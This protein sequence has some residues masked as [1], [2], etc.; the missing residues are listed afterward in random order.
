MQQLNILCFTA[1][2]WT[3]E[4]QNYL[5]CTLVHKNLLLLFFQ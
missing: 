5:Q 2:K 3:T 4:K 1:G